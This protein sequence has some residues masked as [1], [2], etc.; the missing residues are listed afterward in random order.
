MA[1]KAT[2]QPTGPQ[3]IRTYRAEA[4]S[5]TALT[6]GYGVAFGTA[7]DQ[8]KASTGVGARCAGVVLET[9]SVSNDPVAICRHGECI[10]ISGQ[11]TITAGMALKMDADGKMVT[12][13]AAD[14][15]RVGYA[16]G[17]ATS[18]DDEFTMFVSLAADRS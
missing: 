14:N 5:V 16:V 13:E 4:A 1:A 17:A 18:E 10:A 3:N 2:L 7:Q 11:S 9:V 8:V 6:R 12:A 15:E